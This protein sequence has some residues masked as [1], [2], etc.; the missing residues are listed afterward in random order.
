MTAADECLVCPAGYTCPTA[1]L[2]S[3]TISACTVGDYCPEQST[4]ATSCPPGRWSNR[5][6]LQS[7]SDCSLAPAGY[8]APGGGRRAFSC[9]AGYYCPV[10]SS[11]ATEESC[12][13]GRY[14]SETNLY[15]AEQCTITPAGSYS[16]VAAT[17]ALACPAGRFAPHN[18]TRDAGPA[19]CDEHPSP[20]SEGSSSCLQCFGGYACAEGAVEA[21]ACGL[22]YYSAPGASDCA[23]CPRGH[24]CGSNTTNMSSMVLGGLLAGPCVNGTL[25]GEGMTREPDLYRDP[26]PAGAWCDT[27]AEYPTPCAAGR[28]NQFLGAGDIDDCTITPKGYYTVEGASNYTGLCSPGYFCPAGSTTPDDT[29][30]PNTTCDLFLSRGSHL[31]RRYNPFYGRGDLADCSLC[32]AGGLCSSSVTYIIF[33]F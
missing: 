5:T 18:G 26:C 8:Y 25:C 17:E 4:S 9:S 24:W 1:G 30:C 20:C 16:E 27:G 28:V 2:T 7:A 13:A 12:P 19:F 33:F 6:N 3:K 14:S 23:L 10:G 29:P 11:S 32:V 22:G 15:A 31:L 21:V